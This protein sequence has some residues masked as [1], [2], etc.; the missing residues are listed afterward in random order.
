MGIKDK[1]INKSLKNI[2][3]IFS[4]IKL[5]ITIKIILYLFIA[6]LLIT[7]FLKNEWIEKLFHF[8]SREYKYSLYLT[9]ISIPLLMF[10]VAMLRSISAEKLYK[11]NL[12]SFKLNYQPIIMTDNLEYNKDTKELIFKFTNSGK[13][14]ARITWLHINYKEPNNIN[15]MST[16][17][18][19]L[20]LI[21][22]PQK[23]K[24]HRIKF[25]HD[26][27]Q[28]IES[29]FDNEIPTDLEIETRYIGTNKINYEI[30]ELWRTNKETKKFDLINF[31]WFEKT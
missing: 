16:H 12:E 20:S 11:L 10:L 6:I 26:K 1:A 17:Y 13:Y 30:N 2:F 24:E 3:I 27:P 23:L 8:L 19:N 4:K 25:K 7:P 28:I 29:W 5:E 14:P 15:R 9:G 22:I 18:G 31:E 21:V